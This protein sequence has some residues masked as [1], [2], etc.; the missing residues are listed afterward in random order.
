[1]PQLPSGRKVAMDATHLSEIAE[2]NAQTVQR[3]PIHRVKTI[4]DLYPF[5]DVIFF[6][7]TPEDTP[8]SVAYAPGARHLEEVAQLYPYRR[9]FT[10]ATLNEEAHTWPPED[11]QAWA[12]FLQEPRTQA[13]LQGVLETVLDS[14]RRKPPAH[15]PQGLFGD[16]SG[17]ELLD[18][19]WEMG[20]R[21]PGP[22]TPLTPRPEGIK[23][24][25][26]DLL[27]ALCRMNGLQE[28]DEWQTRFPDILAGL[29][30][31]LQRLRDDDRCLSVWLQYWVVDV[32]ELA[33]R[34]R[35]DRILHRLNP[36]TPAW[37]ATQAPQEALALQPLFAEPEIAEHFAPERAILEHA[38]LS[39]TPVG[40][41]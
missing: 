22:E 29:E 14:Q 13:H 6:K 35:G 28:F 21:P 2:L 19:F 33:G 30:A 41:A 9:G 40:S 12:D 16:L 18:L 34:M 25:D 38:A 27:A 1:M 4:A 20:Q 26:Y 24:D 15:L 17:D 39:L 31:F 5:I 10:L 37:F 11:R 36:E 3:F 7:A 32:E 23:V 8:S